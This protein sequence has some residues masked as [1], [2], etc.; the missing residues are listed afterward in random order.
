MLN[1]EFCGMSGYFGRL[2]MVTKVE[3]RIVV[4]A[5][6]ILLGLVL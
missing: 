2:L 4:V 3:Q 6:E 1:V 5:V